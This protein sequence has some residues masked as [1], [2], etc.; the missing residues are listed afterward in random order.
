MTSDQSTADHLRVTTPGAT[1]P[2][3]IAPGAARR[4][5]DLADALS[6][7]SRRVVVSNSTVWRVHAASLEGVSNDDPILLPD[8]ERFKHLQTVSRIYDALIRAGADRATPRGAEGQGTAADVECR[9]ADPGQDDGAGRCRPA[10]QERSAMAAEAEQDRAARGAK[11]VGEEAD[12]GLA[13]EGQ[14][15]VEQHQQADPLEW[16]GAVEAAE[17]HPHRAVGDAV[18]EAE[19]EGHE[20]LHH[21]LLRSLNRGC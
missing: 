3:E 19:E 15:V 17:L 10:Q 12:E 21:W 11:P 6:L 7:P 5:R 18:R 9:R 2:V 14:Q 13:A 4:V 20:V 8:G 1:Y 16:D